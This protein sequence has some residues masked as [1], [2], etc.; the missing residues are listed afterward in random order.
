M[1]LNVLIKKTI[2]YYRRK[3]ILGTLRRIPAKLRWTLFRRR[4]ILYVCDLVNLDHREFSL[5]EQTTVEK[6]KHLQ[7]LTSDEFKALCG[8]QDAAVFTAE[9]RSRFNRGSTLWIIKYQEKTAGM[10]WTITG[11]TIEPHYVCITEFDAHLYNGKIL[12]DFR[13]HGLFPALTHYILGELK[14]EGFVRAYVETN[15]GNTAAIRA[16]E[17]ISVKRVA[18][19]RK[20]R[21][22]GRNITIWNP[23][24]NAS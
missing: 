11:T 17:K 3:G 20:Y 16:F 8:E 4:D 5:P 10:F 13:G 2:H 9:L 1:S 21:L 6:K 22:F 24:G 7:Q 12:D 18:T 14:K 23:E 15:R 19:A